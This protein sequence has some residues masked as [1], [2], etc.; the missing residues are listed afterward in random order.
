MTPDEIR[1]AELERD[2]L[3]RINTHTHSSP[4]VRLGSGPGWAHGGRLYGSQNEAIEMLTAQIKS[5]DFQIRALEACLIA[6]HAMEPKHSQ[7]DHE[8]PECTLLADLRAPENQKCEKCL[9]NYHTGPCDAR[10]DAHK[11]EFCEECGYPF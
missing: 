9:G 4:H 10:C 3:L 5:Q 2:R 11:L 7:E 1:S 6:R 8:C